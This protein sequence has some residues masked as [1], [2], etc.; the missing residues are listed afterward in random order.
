MPQRYYEDL[1]IGE[2]A[3]SSERAV[4]LEE[5]LEFARRYDP[6]YFHADPEAAKASIFGE[7]IASGIHTAALWRQLDA[8]ISGDIAWVCGVAWEDVRWPEAVRA[9]DRL[10]ARFE[11]LAKRPSRSH[12]DRGVVEVRYTLLNQRDAVVFTCRSIN[13]VATRPVT[14][15]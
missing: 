2:I 8:S 12:P 7:V 11:L 1:A 10:R 15:D 14:A 3:E 5:M 6:Q 4:A 13:L 9:G